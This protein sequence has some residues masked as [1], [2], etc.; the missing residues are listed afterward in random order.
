MSKDA[1]LTARASAKTS[2]WIVRNGFEVKL[3]VA[4]K[5][6]LDTSGTPIWISL[7]EILHKR[8]ILVLLPKLSRHNTD[9]LTF[10]GPED[11]VQ[12]QIGP[13]CVE[14]IVGLD[15]MFGGGMPMELLQA[16]HSPV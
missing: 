6:R 13:V 16:I 8:I 11:P 7:Q 2:H 14:Q 1:A 15:H 10:Q 12:L 3:P 9:V 4:A 5:K